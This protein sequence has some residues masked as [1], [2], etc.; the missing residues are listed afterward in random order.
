MGSGATLAS[1][2]GL[3]HSDCGAYSW[4]RMSYRAPSWGITV[5]LKSDWINMSRLTCVKRV[6]G[7]RD[8]HR[9]QAEGTTRTEK[10][11]A[12]RHREAHGSAALLY[13][14]GGKRAHG[15]SH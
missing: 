6:A 1:S 13:L 9:R 8:G 10:H 2:L 5:E 4:T 14:A 11:V 15:T 12:G 3:G 7:G